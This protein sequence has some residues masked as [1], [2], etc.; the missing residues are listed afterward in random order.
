MSLISF[1][2]AFTTPKKIFCSEVNE[3][4]E[5][6]KTTNEIITKQDIEHSL[7]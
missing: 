4:F 1:F 7:D 2:T 3:C 5:R 6:Q